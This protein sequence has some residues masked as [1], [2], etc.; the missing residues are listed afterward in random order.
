MASIGNVHTVLIDKLNGLEYYRQSPPKSLDNSFGSNEVYALIRSFGLTHNDS[1][2]TYVEHILVQIKN[3]ILINRQVAGKNSKLLVTG[4]GAFNS[5]LLTRL[6][7]ELQSIN[8]EVVVAD[9]QIIKYKEALIMGFIGVLRWRQ[10]YTVLPSVTGGKR[11][12]IGGTVWIG[13]EA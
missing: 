4:G 8:I 3:A 2:R 11:S 13:Q 5:F 12:S 7:E 10:E 1:L 9:G 6:K